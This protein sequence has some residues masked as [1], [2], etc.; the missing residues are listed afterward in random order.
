MAR[1]PNLHS[2]PL[3]DGTV[4]WHWKPSPRCRKAGW[5]NQRLGEGP[6][7][8]RGRKPV[9]PHE[10][11]AKAGEW[12]RK[13]DA[14][15]LGC[16]AVADAQ[17]A[18]PLPRKWLF[19]DLLDAYRAS[20]EFSL[21]SA[22][23]PEGI[24]Q[25]TR[26]EYETR[27]GQLRFWAQD[28]ALP[29][30]SIDEEMV[31][32]LKAA[33]LAP[34]AVA[35]E[36]GGTELVPGSKFKCASILRVLRLLMRFAVRKRAIGADPTEGVP[37]PTPPSRTQ[38]LDW[39]AARTIAEDP[40]T[41]PIAARYLR[42]GF[43]TMQRREDMRLINRLAWRELH[44]ADPRDLPALVNGKGQVWGVRLQQQKTGRWVDCPIP[45]FLHA[46]IE[47]AFEHSQWLFPHP[48][49]PAQPISGAV[50]RRRVKPALVASGFPDH[51]LRDLRRSGMSGV[52]DLGA[53]KSDVF[54][55]SGHPLDGQTRTMADVY[56]PPDTMA[57][58]R[59]IAAACRTLA[60]I[61]AREKEEAK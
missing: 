47:A 55:I 51:Q 39:R 36:G 27:F 13:L 17:D 4:A 25:A 8:A 57:A 49:D 15:D 12:N 50:L 22:A 18:P 41:H 56:M 35:A 20:E 52:K 11:V 40:A 46:E 48:T 34:R 37:I 2:R 28:G 19:T 1:I 5:E 53:Q 44:G 60:A 7:P 16:L 10:I 21:K 14:W 59:A 30:R 61:E 38:R 33:L 32:E 23:N 24:A 6:A 58:C 29:L 42:L 26:D 54:A 9:P 31:L 3:A 43:W 45:P